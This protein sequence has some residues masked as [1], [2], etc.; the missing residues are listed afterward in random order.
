MSGE[1]LPHPNEPPA[2]SDQGVTPDLQPDQQT[3]LWGNP[4][5]LLR[6]RRPKGKNGIVY[7]GS[8]VL[9]QDRL[10]SPEELQIPLP[11]TPIN[12]TPDF[13]ADAADP[14]TL[15]YTPDPPSPHA[16]AALFAAP[17]FDTHTLPPAS[18]TQEPHERLQLPIDSDVGD[19]PAPLAPESQPP[20]EAPAAGLLIEAARPLSYTLAYYDRSGDN[21]LGRF[22]TSWRCQKH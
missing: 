14:G 4:V 1:Q 8:T 20:Q 9:K 11:D 2:A 13:S 10:F 16:Q 6:A 18:D 22:S 7:I 5:E 17:P 21:Q 15:F 12:R 19:L 3:D